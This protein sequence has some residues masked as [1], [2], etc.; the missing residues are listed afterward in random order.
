MKYV[1]NLLGLATSVALGV[2]IG[3]LTFKADEKSCQA[4]YTQK[5]ADID[6]KFSSVPTPAGVASGKDFSIEYVVSQD[7]G[8]KGLVFKDALTGR[9]GVFTK[10]ALFGNNNYGMQYADIDAALKSV[11]ASV[12]LQPQVK[13]YVPGQDKTQ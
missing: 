6:E 9:K 13:L 4:M 1:G 7:A 11:Q 10:V 2:G 5:I 3:Y 8:F 12:P